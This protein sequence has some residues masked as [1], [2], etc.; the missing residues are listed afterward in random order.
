ERTLVTT[1][2]KK[3][4][5]ELTRFLEEKKIRVRYL[6]S[7]INALDRI[8]I[9]RDLRMGEFDCLIGINLLREGLDLP[10]VALV[11]V[12]DADKEGFLRSWTSLIQVA[13]R[14][15]RNINGEVILYADSITRSMRK[16][17]DIT[18]GRRAKQLSYN[19]EHGITPKTITKA[20]KEGIE[21]YKQ[22]KEI[23]K[24]VAAET[25]EEYDIREVIAQL[26]YEMENAARDLQFEKAIVYRDQIS[27]LKKMLQDS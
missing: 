9:I 22:A 25:E 20:I 8:E 4:A 27:R 21:A 11:A 6:H 2:T 14:A 17:I 15:A 24:E 3:M 23:V 13:G 1:L 26:E 10:E 18:A 7:E 16:T 19:Q 12:L 5:E